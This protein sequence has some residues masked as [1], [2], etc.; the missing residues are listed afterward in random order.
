MSDLEEADIRRL[1]RGCTTGKGK[2][3]GLEVSREMENQIVMDL[4][5]IEGK[6]T[7]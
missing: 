5:D 1:S 6:L 2:L 7:V 4:R 3:E